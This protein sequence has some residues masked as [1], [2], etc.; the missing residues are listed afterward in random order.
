MSLVDVSPVTRDCP[1]AILAKGVFEILSAIHR[2]YRSYLYELS[3]ALADRCQDKA[4]IPAH[5][6]TC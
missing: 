3:M 5:L 1:A 2:S 6:L 4:S